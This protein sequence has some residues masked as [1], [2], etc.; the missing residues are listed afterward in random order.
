LRTGYLQPRP[1]Q[2]KVQGTRR[3]KITHDIPTYKYTFMNIENI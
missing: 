3:H 2:D 1:G